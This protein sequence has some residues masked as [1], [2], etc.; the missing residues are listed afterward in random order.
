MDDPV[1]AD[2]RREPAGAFTFELE[3]VREALEHIL[4]EPLAV[5]RLEGLERCERR[6]L[7]GVEDVVGIAASETGDGSLV[8]QDRVDPPRVG[9]RPDETGELLR[10]WFRPESFHRSD[11]VR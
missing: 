5:V 4:D 6:D 9:P 8:A 2:L 7:R 3:A 11:V 10:V 1:I